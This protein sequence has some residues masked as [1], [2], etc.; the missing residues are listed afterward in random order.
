MM[1]TRFLAVFLAVITIALGG[2]GFSPVTEFPN[3][4]LGADGQPLILDDLKAIADD[5]DLTV[6]DKR[7]TFRDLGIEDEK[8][9]EALLDL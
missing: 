5:P 7:D 3:A 2:C 9:I 4:L 1:M 6:D 8:L